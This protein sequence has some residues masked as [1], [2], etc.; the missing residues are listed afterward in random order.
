MKRHCP[1]LQLLEAAE[2]GHLNGLFYGN[3]VIPGCSDLTDGKTG[4]H[5]IVYEVN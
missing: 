1:D 3:L 5:L 4:Q 2:E